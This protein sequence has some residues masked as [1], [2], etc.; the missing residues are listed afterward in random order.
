MDSSLKEVKSKGILFFTAG[1]FFAFL[2]SSAATATKIGLQAAQP[3]VICIARF[4]LAGV[5]MVLITHGVLRNRMPRAQEWKQLA[6]Y[7]LL[8]ISLYL[9]LY[10]VAMQEI[11]PGLG[12]LAIA[13]NPVLI[14]LTGA[15][16]FKQPIRT[17]TWISLLLCTAGVVTAA[18]PLIQNSYATPTGMLILFISM[19]CYSGGVIYFSRKRWSDLHMLTIN[20]WQTLLGGV[21][22]LPAAALTYQ[23]SLNTWNLQFTGSVLW[24][25]VPVSI[26]AVQLWLF[27]LRDNPVK[28]SF[29]LFLCPVF[30]YLLAN[31]LMKEPIGVFTVTGMALVIGGLYLVQRK[32]TA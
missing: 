4:F 24:L 30:G 20:G 23:P 16:L 11:S 26:F 27:L 19:L 22:L 2:W 1:L 3:F 14:S 10:V 13:T 6:I 25:A 21:F 9:G 28:A 5:V 12:S 7:G 31:L 32:K 29:W 18:W 17:S 8:N 15:L